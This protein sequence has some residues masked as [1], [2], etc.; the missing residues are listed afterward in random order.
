[1]NKLSVPLIKSLIAKGKTL[2]RAD[3]GG[4]NLVIN[5]SGSIHWRLSYRMHGRQKTLTLGSYPALTLAQARK[6]RDDVKSKIR[7]GIDPIR[8]KEKGNT[9]KE[10]AKQWFDTNLALTNNKGLPQ[11]SEK[12]AKRIWKSLEDNIFSHIGHYPIGSID[13]IKLTEVLK[14]IEARGALEYLSKIRS[15]CSKIF[16]YA[17]IKKIITINPAEDLE[18]I[19]QSPTPKNYN[20]IKL[21][22]LPELIESID[23]HDGEVTTNTGLK[24]ALHTFLRTNEIRFST[25]D[26]IDFENKMWI[27]PANRMKMKREHMVPMSKQV[28]ELLEGLIPHTGRYEYIFAST[29]KPQEKPFSENAMLYALYRLGWKGRM[30]VHGF[31]HLASTTLR[32]LGYPMHLVEKQLSHESKNKVEAAYNKAEYLTD[33][34]KMMNE[35]SAFLENAIGQKNLTINNNPQYKFQ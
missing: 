18:T 4:L 8:K 34:V 10:I 22:H 26:E 7:Q 6:E 15:I 20:S 33:R 13:S 3:G 30:T 5:N 29:Q 11:W 35:W 21:T 2:K 16:V 24:I 23:G 19:L 14:I 28:I 17:R 27:V 9:F 32:E 31:R 1:M 12:H 25:W